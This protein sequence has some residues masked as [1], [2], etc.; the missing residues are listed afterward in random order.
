MQ[1]LSSLWI[2]TPLEFA[3]AL[4]TVMA[5]GIV[6]GYTGFG[7]GLVMVPLLALLWGPVEALATMTGL[8][9]FATLQL[10]PRAIPLTN[11]R[12]VGPMVAG[13]LAL[14]PAGTAL[15]VSL[16]P[17]IVKKIIATLVLVATLIT[18]S[19]WV[20]RG[21]RGLVPGFIS[22]G[23]TGLIN[24][25]AGVGGPATVLYLMAIPGEAQAQRANIV[26]AMAFVT[27][28]V[29][30]AMIFAGVV[31]PRVI[32]HIAVFLIPS[33]FSVWLGVKMF[34][35]LPSKHFKTLVLWFLVAIS[36]MILAA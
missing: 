36:V 21:P 14:T 3:L 11:W 30:V 33:I 9:T 8:G 28:S 17:V 29:F 35:V 10:I 32:T 15:L 12:D 7:S 5:G 20:Y 18:M 22:G 34:H 19:G 16:D 26:S 1:F 24:G 25:L 2:Y 6:R 31:T 13:S 23:L 27:I 4:A